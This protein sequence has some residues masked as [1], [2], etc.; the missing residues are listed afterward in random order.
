MTVNLY[1]TQLNTFVSICISSI[2]SLDIHKKKNT[3]VKCVSLSVLA[4]CVTLVSL[5]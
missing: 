1:E 5:Y 4:K 3:L 2:Q